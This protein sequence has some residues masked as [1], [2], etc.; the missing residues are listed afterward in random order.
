MYDIAYLCLK[1]FSKVAWFIPMTEVCGSLHKAAHVMNQGCT[2]S[3]PNPHIVGVALATPAV[4]QHPQL[5]GSA[6]QINTMACLV[7]FLE[8]A[9]FGSTDSTGNDVNDFQPFLSIAVDL[10]T[11]ASE[12]NPQNS[13]LHEW[14]TAAVQPSLILG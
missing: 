13:S 12:S 11:T 8:K 14:L 10:K 1:N 7:T 5:Y 4:N 2:S 6:C 3:E 9:T